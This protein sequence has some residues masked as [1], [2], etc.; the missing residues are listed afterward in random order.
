VFER[1]GTDWTQSAKLTASDVT[2]EGYFGYSVAATNN[3]VLVG[4][5][6]RMKMQALKR[7]RPIFLFDRLEGGL[8]RMKPRM[9]P[10][11]LKHQT[12]QHLINSAFLSRFLATRPW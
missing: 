6:T 3:T 4:R 7:V 5:I 12:Q 2:G 8:L 1:N 9:K 10:P 11:S